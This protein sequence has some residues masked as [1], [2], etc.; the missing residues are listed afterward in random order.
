MEQFIFDTAS[1]HSCQAS[2]I[3]ETPEGLVAAWF[4]GT[5]EGHPVVCIYISRKVKEKWTVPEYSEALCC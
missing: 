1:F 2:S 3:A 4:G 5:K